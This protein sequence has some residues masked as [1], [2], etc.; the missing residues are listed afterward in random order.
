[1]RFAQP[2]LYCCYQNSLKLG[3]RFFIFASCAQHRRKGQRLKS[4]I[5]LQL[6]IASCRSCRK[7]DERSFC[8]P[9]AKLR[10]PPPLTQGRRI[11]LRERRVA[12]IL[13]VFLVLHI[14][15]IFGFLC[16]CCAFYCYG[17]P[18]RGS[19]IGF[20]LSIQPNGEF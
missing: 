15:T 8:N 12:F 9:S 18:F 10:D 17:A 20:A 7:A 14:F 4:P 16:R 6:G 1:M 3:Y 13:P 2:L 19:F 11:A 5:V